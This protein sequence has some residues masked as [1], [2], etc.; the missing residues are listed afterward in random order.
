MFR[1]I[2]QPFYT[3]YVLVTFVACLLICF[4]FFLLISAGNNIAARKAI[5]TIIKYWAKG[6]LWIIGMPLKT[7]GAK[8]PPGRYV[9]VAN[10]ISYMDTIAI[11]AAIPF[12][13]RALGKK[14]ISGIPILGFLYRQIVV[15]V[16]RDSPKSRALSMRLMWRVLAHESSITIFPEGTFNETGEPLKEFYNGAFRLA[17]SS[18]T[19]ILPLIFAD[20][21]KRWDYRAWWKL[22]PGR[23]RAIFLSPIEVKGVQQQDINML[24]Q[25]VYE[26]M[27]T[28]I[29]KISG[30]L[31]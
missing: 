20:M 15:M 24:K 28:E 16:D 2:F 10:H 5:Y 12:Y 1:K 23:N 25:T 13:F 11:F 18:Q 6:W 7:S 22:W 26:A 29:I 27:Q 3:L 21:E 31:K 30:K 9:I 19:P 4:P 17:I 14:E 8:P